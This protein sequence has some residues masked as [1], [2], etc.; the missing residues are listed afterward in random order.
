MT[1]CGWS[2][3]DSPH[4]TL[5]RCRPILQVPVSSPG[6]A[7][8]AAEDV[9]RKPLPDSVEQ[10]RCRQRVFV[11]HKAGSRAK[12]LRRRSSLA[13]PNSLKGQ[14]RPYTVFQQQPLFSPSGKRRDRSSQR[15]L[16]LAHVGRRDLPLAQSQAGERPAAMRSSPQTKTGGI[17][18]A[19][20]ELY[21]GSL[22]RAEALLLRARRGL[23]EASQTRHSAP[24]SP[25]KRATV[26]MSTSSRGQ[27]TESCCSQCCSCGHASAKTL[28]AGEI[29]PLQ[30]APIENHV[31]Q[32]KRLSVA[33]SPHQSILSMAKA[34]QPPSRTSSRI[35]EIDRFAKQLEVFADE[36]K[37]RGRLPPACTPTTESTSLHTV[38][39]LL[40][41][42]AELQAAGLAVTSSDQRQ[43]TQ[44]SI[45]PVAKPLSPQKSLVLTVLSSQLSAAHQIDGEKG[46]KR[47]AAHVPMISVGENPLAVTQVQDGC[48]DLLCLPKERYA[49]NERLQSEQADA[50]MALGDQLPAIKE[51]KGL[52]TSKLAGLSNCVV[53]AKGLGS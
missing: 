29:N 50:T 52:D 37:A 36:T 17:T 48:S 41:F 11:A 31:Q 40:P 7:H 16:V 25:R 12:A 13:T 5:V 26:Q 6:A 38:V 34:P 20:D 49:P 4:D 39:P 43:R 30:A 47:P 15:S 2:Y 45:Q 53:V 24:T 3:G 19:A 1:P 32:Q 27:Q 28:V 46:S 8:R 35:K 42:R 33:K 23:R 22:Q 51:D 10:L 18:G 9:F 14:R 44:I 21:M